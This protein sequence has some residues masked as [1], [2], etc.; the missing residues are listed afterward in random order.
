LGSKPD[1]SN[2]SDKFKTTRWSTLEVDEWGMT[3]HKCIFAAGDIV[4]GPSTIVDAIGSGHCAANGIVKFLLGE[5]G[6]FGSKES[7]EML[8]VEA[9]TPECQDKINAE[10]ISTENRQTTFDEV[11]M[12]MTEADALAEANRCRRC[13][14]CSVC[15]VVFQHA[16]IEMQLSQFSKPENQHSPKFPLTSQRIPTKA[17]KLL[18]RIRK[19][20]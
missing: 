12:G 8:I 9:L 15:S 20:P 16:I 7:K 17:G 1:I 6:E 18:Q 10:C 4:S 3:S 2:F 13:G 5:E 19:Q 14:S 11:E